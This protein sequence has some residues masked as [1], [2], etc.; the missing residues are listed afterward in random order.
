MNRY[1][2][3]LR[4]FLRMITGDNDGRM[5]KDRMYSFVKDIIKTVEPIQS[6]I[7]GPT[8]R[9]S[10]TLKDG[11]LPCAVL[12]SKQRVVELA[13]RRIKEDMDR[14]PPAGA[15][16][17]YTRIVSVFVASGNRINDYEVSSAS[18]SQYAPPPALLSQIEGET[19]MGWTGWV[20]KMKDGKAIR[21]L[22]EPGYKDYDVNSV[23]TNVS[24]S[25]VRS[26][27]SNARNQSHR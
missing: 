3:R 19:M 17:P 22:H 4:R 16:A 9:C 12:Q 1:V 25:V 18:V 26:M 23:F 11:T 24:F 13:K 8:Y 6:S 21:S 20:F 2:K 5:R 27:G 14:E 15:L 7:Y 10:L